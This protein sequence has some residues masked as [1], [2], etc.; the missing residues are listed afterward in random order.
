MSDKL[1]INYKLLETLSKVGV[2]KY[3][4]VIWTSSFGE[5][6]HIELT[7]EGSEMIMFKVLR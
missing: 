7:E 6:V 5:I 3:L 4:I 2:I 1:I